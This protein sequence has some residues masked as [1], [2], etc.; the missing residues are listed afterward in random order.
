M[1][2]IKDRADFNRKCL[3]DLSEFLIYH[4][5]DIAIGINDF[6]DLQDLFY[7]EVGREAEYNK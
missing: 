7:H 3:T 1:R 6:G 4:E 2:F 5:E